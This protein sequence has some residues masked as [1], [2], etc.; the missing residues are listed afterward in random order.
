MKVWSNLAKI[1]TRRTYSRPF[2]ENKREDW[3]GIIT[4]TILGNVRNCEVSSDEVVQLHHFM[5]E[6]KATPGGRGLWFSGTDAHKKL[7][8]AALINCWYVNTAN[9][10]NFVVAQDL[11]M[12]GGGVGVSVEHRFSSKLPKVKTGVQIIHKGTKDADFIVPDSREGWNELTYRALESFFVTGKNFTYSTVCLRGYGEPI[13]GFGGVASGPIPL[14]KFIENLCATLIARE[15]KFVRPID[16]ADIT[17]AIGEMVV[18]GNVRRT[19]I[20]LIGDPWDKDFLRAKRWDLGGLPSHRS[21]ANYSVVCDD[22]DDLHPLYWK[23]FEHGEAFGI[24]NRTTTRKYGRMGELK[25]DTAEGYNPCGEAA[26][27][28]YE[29]CNLQEIALPNLKDEDEFVQ[30]ARLMHRYGK[31]VTLESYHNPKNQE[32]VY[33]NRRIGTGITGCLS[34]DLFT[35]KVLD[36]VYS[37]IQDENVKYSKQL[38]IPESIR[39]TVVKPS[40][41]I[42]KVFDMHGYEGIHP[43]YSRYIIQRVRFSSNDPLIPTLR[44][45]G[46]YMEPMMKLDGSHD[47]RTLVVDFY[48]QAPNGFPVAD[49]NFDTWKQLEVFQMAQKHWSD[50]SVSV[51]VYYKKEEIPKIKKWLS[52]NISEVKT[53]SFLCHSD[54]G[55]NQAPKEAITQ[56]KF[57]QLSKNVTPI[58][59]DQ[60]GEGEL[61][62][63]ECQGGQCPVK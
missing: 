34:S 41:T 13:R 43:A 16:A 49:E 33:R 3:G 40:G 42:S 37:A 45:A 1:V 58:D 22:T 57:E 23:T 4:R 25:K 48:E 51:S 53:I 11:F 27:E 18:S 31:R 38:K 17:T 9:W 63:Q 6:R 19:A 55:Y 46:H 56:E 7:G 59:W 24:I 28:P 21:N 52:E 12:L 15:G 29:P 30:A 20:I 8:G 62:T 14:I 54:H 47:P 35:P 5:L 2:S 26:L 50:Q 32:V 10:E 39:T 61:E 60:I 44:A 36:R